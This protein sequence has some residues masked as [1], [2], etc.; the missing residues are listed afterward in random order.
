MF[1]SVYTG[2]IPAFDRTL[3]KT[4]ECV[5]DSEKKKKATT[6]KSVLSINSERDAANGKC[7]L[8]SSCAFAT[9]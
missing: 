8:S 1:E 5:S 4:M 6:S 2:T 9:L 7:F 3:I